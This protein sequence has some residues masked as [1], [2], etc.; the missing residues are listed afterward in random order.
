[1]KYNQLVESVSLND[2]KN[3][4]FMQEYPST[5]LY[6]GIKKDFSDITLIPF[7]LRDRP[8]DTYGLIHEVVNEL[9]LSKFGFPIRSLSFTTTS[10]K[11][12]SNYGTVYNIVPKGNFKLFSNPT[13]SDFAF[14]DFGGSP[15]SQEN[16]TIRHYAMD[17]ADTVLEFDQFKNLSDK[18]SF[19]LALNNHN[20][21][22]L[23]LFDVD[24]WDE[25]MTMD[26]LA[27]FIATVFFTAFRDDV[28]Y[29]DNDTDWLAESI[30]QNMLAIFK[31]ETRRYI[32]QLCKQYVDG[33]VELDTSNIGYVAEHHTEIMMYAPNGFYLIPNNY[34]A[35][36]S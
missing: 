12:A 26:G 25:I 29:Y 23:N 4:P 5:K 34:K 30:Y 17:I 28:T 18:E 16:N 9:S 19:Q 20:M 13:I 22:Y 8:L 31:S 15:V 14:S 10:S 35:D 36:E 33:V 21:E 1:M 6:K 32:Y 3:E 2:I 11:V 27:E 24:D 7:K